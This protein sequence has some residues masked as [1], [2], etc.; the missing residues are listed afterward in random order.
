MRLGIICA[1]LASLM[2]FPATAQTPL[3]LRA[4]VDTSATHG[5]TIA[6]ADYLKKL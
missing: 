6:V 4:S 3:K 2:S 5:R 1:V